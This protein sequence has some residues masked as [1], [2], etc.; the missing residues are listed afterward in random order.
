MEAN[1]MRKGYLKQAY[2]GLCLFMGFMTLSSNAL[3]D[4]R[5][6]L[7]EIGQRTMQQNFVSE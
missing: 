6:K 2:T 5:E 3:A 7:K 4:G 1:M